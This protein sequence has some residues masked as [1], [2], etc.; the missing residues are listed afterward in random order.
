MRPAGPRWPAAR[1][2]GPPIRVRAASVRAGPFRNFPR[3]SKHPLPLGLPPD[4]LGI[5]SDMCMHRPSLPSVILPG[6]GFA[7][8]RQRG[9]RGAAAAA[10]VFRHP[11]VRRR[12]RVEVAGDSSMLVLGAHAGSPPRGAGPPIGVRGTGVRAGPVSNFPRNIK[13]PRPPRSSLRPYR[14]CSDMCIHRPSLPSVI[15]PRVGL[16]PMP[17][18]GGRGGA[19]AA[20]AFRHPRLGARTRVEVAGGSSMPA[21]GAHA[22]S[23]PR[24]AGP[25][26]GVRW[27]GGGAGPVCKFPRY[28]KISRP[29]RCSLR[30][31]RHCSD[32]CI[33][34]PSLPSVIYPAVGFAPMPRWGGR[35][36][37]SRPCHGARAP[38]PYG[39]RG[40]RERHLGLLGLS[41]R[42]ARP[43]RP[44]RAS[45]A[46]GTRVR[47]VPVCN[48][49]RYFGTLGV[50]FGRMPRRGGREGGRLLPR[51]DFRS[52]PHKSVASRRACPA[53]FVPEGAG[54]RPPRPRRMGAAAGRP[55]GG[56]APASSVGP[57]GTRD[58]CDR[59]AHPVRPGRVSGPFPFAT[60]LGTLERLG[61]ALGGC[62]AGVVGRGGLL[63]PRPAFRSTPHRT[64]ASRRACPAHLVP[65]G[66]GTRLP[67]SRRTGAAFGR[68]CP[69]AVRHFGSLH[70]PSR[71]ARPG[72][73]GCAPRATGTRVRAVSVC[74]APRFAG[75]LG[76]GL[77][78]M[79][80]WG[81]K[82][83]CPAWACLPP[84]P[85]AQ[86]GWSRRAGGRAARARGR[87]PETR[88]DGRAGPIGRS[89][90]RFVVLPC[91]GARAAA[92]WSLGSAHL[93]RADG[94]VA[95]AAGP[96]GRAGR[97]PGSR[98]D[99]RARPIGLSD[100]RAVPLS[101]LGARASAAWSLGSAQGR[102]PPAERRA[103]ARARRGRSG[104]RA[105]VAPG[106]WPGRARSCSFFLVRARHGARAL[107][108]PSVRARARGPP[109]GPARLRAPRLARAGGHQG[110]RA[111]GC[112]RG[113]ARP[114]VGRMSV[115]LGPN[116]GGALGVRFLGAGTVWPVGLDWRVGA[117]PDGAELGSAVCGLASKARSLSK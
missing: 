85:V 25:P 28:F 62:P 18:W 45:R 21:P 64:V 101:R 110:P 79:P 17:R 114:P 58:P 93:A 20:G 106:P 104:R 65:D 38:A 77:R 51:R 94:R 75:A 1:N 112:A 50:G 69:A 40:G 43:V 4:P 56:R 11:R 35:G 70:R 55:R 115:A 92:A 24:G 68:P 109:P 105:A 98:K 27:T 76:V 80:R 67:T 99:G 10:A 26:I 61:W 59:D 111:A 84:E 39:P 53:P 87:W 86:R 97:C 2:A 42:D 91:L 30:P 8:T 46:T 44:G 52:T 57:P 71:E 96:R 3:Y 78:R 116:L 95:R 29:C 6:V 82:G 15:Y 22:G 100:A 90:A 47:A 49:P 117:A 63:P 66:A 72:R 12:I 31:Y 54:P 81:G 9:G 103:G 37:R 60:L 107:A 83:V 16:A 48:A 41:S 113:R 89:G 19:A 36:A 13:T 34:R 74:N 32:M 7:P 108:P 23:P 88:K 33:H 102:A 14:Y 5:C 73:S